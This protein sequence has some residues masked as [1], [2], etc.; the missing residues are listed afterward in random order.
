MHPSPPCPLNLVFVLC[1]SGSEQDIS[2]PRPL[3]CAV[4][5]S[6]IA[7]VNAINLL[8]Q[9]AHR[10]SSVPGTLKRTCYLV[11]GEFS[12]KLVNS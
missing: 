2:Q 8:E 7:P 5:H 4:H 10:M 11:L 1:H 12:R 6:G 9:R 3:P